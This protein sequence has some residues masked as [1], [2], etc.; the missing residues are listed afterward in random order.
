M[1]T[2]PKCPEG[3]YWAETSQPEYVLDVRVTSL[4]VKVSRSSASLSIPL[5]WFLSISPHPAP[6]LRNEGRALRYAPARGHARAPSCGRRSH[7]EP[8]RR[9]RE[10]PKEGRRWNSTRGPGPSG[11]TKTAGRWRSAT[12]TRWRRRALYDVFA[13]DKA[14]P[15]AGTPR[16]PG[17]ISGAPRA[18][19]LN[20]D[21]LLWHMD[22]DLGADEARSWGTWTT[23]VATRSS[24]R[25]TW[26]QVCILS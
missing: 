25:S 12:S 11:T 14:D 8:A 15:D 23:T 22:S 13:G 24:S 5:A 9:R 3:C 16:S 20:F 1:S 7:N 26:S 6:P 10:R 21:P 4:T 19:T 2:G 17:Y 18:K